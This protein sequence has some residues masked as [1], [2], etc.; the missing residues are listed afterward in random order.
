MRM[1]GYELIAFLGK[2]Y[3]VPN[4]RREYEG[5]VEDLT[6][7]QAASDEPDV[8]HSITV[9]F[10]PLRVRCD[11]AHDGRT[12]QDYALLGFCT[13]KSIPVEGFGNFTW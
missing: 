5:V 9:Y 11:Y 2:L 6:W 1:N 3:G 13:A 10:E 8:F 12:E 4:S 7:F